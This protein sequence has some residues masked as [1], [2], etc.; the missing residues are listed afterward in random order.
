[1]IVYIENPKGSIKKKRLLELINEFSKV[2]GYN[3]NREKST[4]SLYTGNEYVDT[5]I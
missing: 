4:G 1:M 2:V 5:K 3:I